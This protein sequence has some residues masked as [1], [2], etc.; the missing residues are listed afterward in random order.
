MLSEWYAF[1]PDQWEPEP[2]EKPVLVQGRPAGDG[3]Y[4]QL[5]LPDPLGKFQVFTAGDGERSIAF[6]TLNEIMNQLE[7]SLARAKALAAG[8][9]DG[10]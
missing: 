1:W 6:V 3:H 10:D 4:V 7:T 5:S 2:S 9:G 8:Q